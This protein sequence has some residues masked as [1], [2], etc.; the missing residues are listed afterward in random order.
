M[1]ITGKVLKKLKENDILW[2]LINFKIKLK[3][4]HLVFGLLLLN[5]LKN[6]NVALH[7]CVHHSN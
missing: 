4:I 6:C 5:H 2:N 3:I 1:N 7:I